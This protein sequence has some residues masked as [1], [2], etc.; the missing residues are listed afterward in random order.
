MKGEQ[1]GI[2]MYLQDSKQHQI[3]KDDMNRQISELQVLY[4]QE[5]KNG[6]IEINQKE[7]EKI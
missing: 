6:M 2:E 4:K 7:F 5:K 1:E 3:R